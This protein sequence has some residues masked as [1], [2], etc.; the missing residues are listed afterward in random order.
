MRKHGPDGKFVYTGDAIDARGYRR[1]NNAHQHR[2]IVEAILGKPLPPKAEIHHVNG[3]KTD[4][5]P[6]NLVVCPDSAYH[7]LLHLRQK[8]LNEC[9]DAN[10]RWCGYCR[11]YSL[12]HGMTDN[13]NGSFY[14]RACR[15]KWQQVYR[16]KKRAS[17]G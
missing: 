10:K 2:L 7:A 16:A 9:G 12:P 3:I 15:T 11:T 5:R 1:L 13:G 17:N 6:D 14:H 8:A 4:N